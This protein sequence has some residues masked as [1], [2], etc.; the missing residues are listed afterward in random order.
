MLKMSST[1]FTKWCCTNDV[2]LLSVS[3]DIHFND[4]VFVI[5]IWNPYFIICKLFVRKFLSVKFRQKQ[6]KKRE[7]KLEILNMKTIK[8]VYLQFLG[9]LLQVK[10]ANIPLIVDADG[11]WYLTT[12]PHIIKGY[13][14]AV[15]TPNAM[16]FSRL[17]KVRC[18]EILNFK[19]FKFNL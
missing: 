6:I 7:T 9:L 2:F 13:T 15:R 5:Y 14:R 18:L 17:V 11:L 10:T 16:E 1:S 4:P 8:I 19:I 3:G 12:T